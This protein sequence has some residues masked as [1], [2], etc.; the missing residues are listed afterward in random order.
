METLSATF[1]SPSGSKCR[2]FAL[3]LKI[4]NGFVGFFD[5]GRVGGESDQSHIEADAVMEAAGFQLRRRM[6]GHIEI[7][8]S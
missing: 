2:Q 8:R 6:L 3:F 4:R 1:G 5:E 7:A